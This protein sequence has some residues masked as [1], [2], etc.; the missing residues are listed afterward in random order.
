[1]PLGEKGSIMAAAGFGF[2]ERRTIS[3][4]S[5]NITSSLGESATL[6]SYD[7]LVAMAYEVGI[8]WDASLAYRVL[9]VN[10]YLAYDAISAHLFEIGLTKNF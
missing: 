9:N 10:E 1:V 3:N 5:G 8:G 6:F 4:F 7:F 2:A